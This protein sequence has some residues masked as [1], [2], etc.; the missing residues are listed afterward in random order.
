MLTQSI[1]TSHNR[2]DS[3]TQAELHNNLENFIEDSNHQDILVDFAGVD[4]VDSNGLVTL[5]K[6]HKQ[7]RRKNKNFHLFNVSPAVRLILE[8]SQL[9][10][11]LSIKEI[12]CQSNPSY[13]GGLAA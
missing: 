7:A 11:V 6:A 1:F 5:V 2:V 3:L 13:T 9:D 12:N 10:Q 4:F 8:I